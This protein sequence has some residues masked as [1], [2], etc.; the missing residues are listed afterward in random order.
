MT[1]ALDLRIARPAFDVVASFEVPSGRTLALVGPNG[2]GKSTLLAAIA[3]LAD[4]DGTVSLDGREL[5]GF[6]AERR[7][8]G[9]VFQDFLLFP[10]LTVRDNVAFPLRVRGV[11]RSAADPWLERFDL[12]DLE[13]RHPGELSGGQAQ[14]VALARALA[15]DPAVLVLDE[16]MAALDVEIRDEVRADLARYLRAF[17]GPTI[18]VSH[19][20]DDAAALADEIA[21]IERGAIVQRGTLPELAAAPATPWVAR[22]AR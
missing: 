8:V 18:V 4:A 6:P 17:D 14:R 10:H 16:P 21:V 2:A 1:L 12:L 11:E 20:V 19:D 13:A 7:G 22:F 3:G 5:G 9:V 15:S